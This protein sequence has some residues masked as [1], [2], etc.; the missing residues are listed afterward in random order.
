ME[1]DIAF[2][3]A[4]L[5]F[6]VFMVILWGFGNNPLRTFAIRQR[7]EEDEA[8]EESKRFRDLFLNEFDG[9]LASINARNKFRYRVAA[10]GFF[11][12]FL[13]TLLLA[14]YLG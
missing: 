5:I 1:M 7:F 8:D 10:G 6:V 11:A 13:I 12:A 14:M 9:Y 4:S 3:I 2:V